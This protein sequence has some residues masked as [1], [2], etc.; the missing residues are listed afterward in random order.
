MAMKYLHDR[1]PIIIHRDL[2]SHNLLI[3]RGIVKLCD[4]GLVRTKVSQAGTPAY[5]APELL[6]GSTFNKS[7]DV[8]SFGI[9]LCEI[10]AQ[11]IPF[12]GYELDDLRR[13]V[14]RG[15]R[16]RV[17]SLD[18]PQVIKTLMAESWHHNP[19]Q[20]PEFVQIEA[21]LIR[22]LQN[23]PQHS[24][25]ESLESASGFGGDA[26]DDLLCGSGK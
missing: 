16:P 9:L 14:I 22:L 25:V 2:K 21:E 10:F 7:V 6:N 15:E 11:E 3:S 8:Y 13:A 12:N 20:R 4:F 5:M 26:L 18:T 23:T 17:P 1:N 19:Q 24:E